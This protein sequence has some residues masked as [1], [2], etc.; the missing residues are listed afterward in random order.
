MPE[1]NDDHTMS[2]DRGHTPDHS[3]PETVPPSS[4]LFAMEPVL[5][6]MESFIHIIGH[7][8][9]SI[10]EVQEDEWRAV[11][12]RLINLHRELDRLWS[13]AFEDRRREHEAHE[14]ALAAAKART[15]PG[16]REEAERLSSLWRLLAAA[17]T[18]TLE[19]TRKAVPDV[20]ASIPALDAGLP[21]TESGRV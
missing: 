6:E 20:V 7:L 15:A 16:S 1:A 9:T 13:A 12:D 14:V 2:S 8:C 3:R 17:A 5:G 18:V 19:Q 21:P 11:E 10:N 4:P